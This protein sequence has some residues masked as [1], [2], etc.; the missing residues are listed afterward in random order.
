MRPYPNCCGN[1]CPSSG[2]W[3]AVRKR[4]RQIWRRR[5][6]W[7]QCSFS[8]GFALDLK[9]GWLLEVIIAETATRYYRAL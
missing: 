2:H 3:A 4:R 5:W 7:C 6:A 1:S 9:S 8:Q